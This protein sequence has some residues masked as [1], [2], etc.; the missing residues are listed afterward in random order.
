MG[1]G[2]EGK[3]GREPHWA[4]CLMSG[5]I[6]DRAWAERKSTTNGDSGNQS[7]FF[8]ILSVIPKFSRI[9]VFFK[10][11]KQSF[12]GF[13]F[14]TEYKITYTIWSQAK[15]QNILT[16][17][18]QNVNSCWFWVVMLYFFSLLLFSIFQTAYIEHILYIKNI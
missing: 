5:S 3:G 1:A 9:N 14:P 12:Q 17:L 15:T 13:F 4:R 8:F 10:L 2:V 7:F 11:W 6:S 18:C 16:E